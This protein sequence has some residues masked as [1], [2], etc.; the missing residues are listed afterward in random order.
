MNWRAAPNFLGEGSARRF[1]AN[2]N[3]FPI[4]DRFA[5]GCLFAALMLGDRAKHF[6][7]SA[8]K[9]GDCFWFVLEFASACERR[10][11]TIDS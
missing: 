10:F 8:W 5:G 4:T 7:T 3:R 6:F 11:R 2:S 9:P 1:F